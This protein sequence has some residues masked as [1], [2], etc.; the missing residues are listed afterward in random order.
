M[1]AAWSPCHGHASSVVDRLLQLPLPIPSFL[2]SPPQ[3]VNPAWEKRKPEETAAAA[4]ISLATCAPPPRHRL[5]ARR[6]GEE[7]R[8]Q[9][10]NE[11][12]DI[13]RPQHR[14][15]RARAPLLPRLSL[16]KK[17]DLAVFFVVGIY[18]RPFCAFSWHLAVTRVCTPTTTK[19]SFFH[20]E[21]EFF[22]GLPPPTPL[23]P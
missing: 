9:A 19:M 1:P 11:E 8:P 23:P 2:R 7:R 17:P 22:L 12:E 20:D 15:P 3:E 16:N 6:K 5:D 4:A 13:S 14:Q 10:Q 18:F 21:M